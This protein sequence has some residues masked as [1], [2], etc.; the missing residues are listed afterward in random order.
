MEQLEQKIGNSL[1]GPK[2]TFTGLTLGIS[3]FIISVIEWIIAIFIASLPFVN[4]AFYSNDQTPRL[5]YSIVFFLVVSLFGVIAIVFSI[6]N[7]VK[8]KRYTLQVV[9]GFVFALLGIIITLFFLVP[10]VKSY[11]ISVHHY[12][13]SLTPTIGESNSNI[14]IT[15]RYKTGDSIYIKWSPETE[16]LIN[17]GTASIYLDYQNRLIAKDIPVS[18]RTY[19]WKIDRDL[20]TGEYKIFVIHKH[21]DALWEENYFFFNVINENPA[22]TILGWKTYTNKEYGYQIN[23]PDTWVAST[24]AFPIPT[25]TGDGSYWWPPNAQKKEEMV[26]CPPEL[27]ETKNGNIVCNNGS[28]VASPFPPIYLFKCSKE[29]SLLETCDKEYMKNNYGDSVSDSISLG[30]D[31]VGNYSYYLIHNIKNGPQYSTTHQLEWD[32]IWTQMIPSFKFIK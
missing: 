12:Y 14:D 1:E 2:F 20:P 27:Q 9:L 24:Y 10:S 13:V 5:E 30:I 19:V 8:N 22:G 31:L 25:K 6:V 15:Y 7:V 16:S 21:D 28:D 29:G 4:S 32:D 3:S 18:I 17:A 23:L 26:F 11:H